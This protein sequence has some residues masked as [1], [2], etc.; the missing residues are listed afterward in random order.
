MI[1]SLYSTRLILGALG[2]SDFGIYSIIGG[3][4]TMLGFIT[5][6]L[7]VTTQRYIS[8]HH[9]RG[10]MDA[11]KKIFFNSLFIH[12]SFSIVISLVLF[13]IKDFV[14]YSWINI[15]EERLAAAENVYYFSIIVLI[16]TI[17]IAPYKAIFIARENIIYISVVEVLDGCLKLILAFYITFSVYDRL[18]LYAIMIALIQFCNLVAYVCYSIKNFDECSITVF[19]KNYIDRD[20]IYNLLGFASWTTYGAG[21]IVLRNQ[22]IAILLNNFFGTVINAAYGIASQIQVALSFVSTSILNAM[23]PQIMKAE[24]AGDRRRMFSLAMHES[25]YSS[26]LMM[27]IAIPVI[28]EMHSILIFWLKDVPKGTEMFCKFMLLSFIVDQLTYGLNT[29]NQALGKIRTYSLFMYTPK[30]VILPLALLSLSLWRDAECVMLI[31][32][33]I[34]LVVSIFRIFYMKHIV[35]FSMLEFIKKAICPLFPLLCILLLV[36]NVCVF[37]VSFPNRFI[38]TLLISFF[39]GGI[40]FWCFTMTSSERLYFRNFL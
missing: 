8:F 28:I 34:E 18:T 26:A 1:L 40:V 25:K 31:Y 19:K 17:L 22:G 3:V 13:L 7:V 21:V 35:E 24:G 11:V 29:A 37:F 12:I 36:G 5:N 4:V 27:I 38:F 33:F 20:S 30:L 9:G 15:P 10:D 23:N 32:F 6:S 39:I 16:I 14:I 2:M